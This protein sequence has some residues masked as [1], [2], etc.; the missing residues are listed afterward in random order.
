MVRSVVVIG[1][2][3]GAIEP[4]QKIV[5]ELPADLP[6]AVLVVI[7]L[8]STRVSRLPDVIT[9]TGRLQA[10]HPRQGESLQE[11]CIYLAPPDLHLLV[12][13]GHVSLARGPRENHS[14]PAIDPLFRTA[15]ESYG[16]RTVALL[17]SGILDDGSAGVLAVERGGGAV[18]LQDPDTALFPDMP[19]S[20]MQLSRNHAVLPPE[21]IAAAIVRATHERGGEAP[22]TMS[23]NG[24]RMPS[25]NGFASTN[26][27]N[28]DLLP[29]GSAMNGVSGHGADD[30]SGLRQ[31]G[32]HSMFAC[33]DCG[34]VLWELSDGDLVRYRCRVGHAYTGEG[35]LVAQTDQAEE[36]LWTA[37][38]SLEEQADLARGL[39]RRMRER[40]RERTV[41]RIDE[42]ID[43]LSGSAR[44][45][46]GLLEAGARI[47]LEEPELLELDKS[48]PPD[49]R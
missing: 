10:K 23:R 16:E 48:P 35:L 19:R 45:L 31:E 13:D 3:A 5:S 8:P 41:A 11:G 7:H 22:T 14:R 20:A 46:R 28:D 36:A 42:R 9:R 38:R 34:G 25:S 43:R 15:A 37:L 33:P 40:G 26:A 39:S 49:S 44:T 24:E 30:G 29:R 32:E 21:E 4:L 18:I 12:K 47:E 27:R 17:L 2:S 6:A 1:G